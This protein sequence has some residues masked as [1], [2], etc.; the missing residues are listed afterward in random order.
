VYRLLPSLK[1]NLNVD[2]FK[3]QFWRRRSILSLAINSNRIFRGVRGSV[4]WT[5]I[6]EDDAYFLPK[7]K[8]H[9]FSFLENSK[10]DV[11]F[12]D[13]R[14]AY[15]YVFL[16]RFCEAS[17]GVAYNNRR[18]NDFIEMSQ[19]DSKYY[20]DHMKSGGR[21]YFPHLIATLCNRN[22][23]VHHMFEKCLMFQVRI[24]N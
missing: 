14:C 8:T 13:A 6:F 23:H 11:I 19:I 1:E 9:F 18:I 20:V 4:D 5:I 10:W 15:P 21:G 22:V 16:R 2:H 12:M 7:F 17:V 24:V 3:N